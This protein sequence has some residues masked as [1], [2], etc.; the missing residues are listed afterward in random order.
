M[1]VVIPHSPTKELASPPVCRLCS[2]EGSPDLFLFIVQL[3]KTLCVYIF[4]KAAMS[5]PSICMDTTGPK[6]F[7]KPPVNTTKP[8]LCTP[9]ISATAFHEF[10]DF[11]KMDYTQ[12]WGS[13]CWRGRR[14]EKKSE[15]KIGQKR[16]LTF[17]LCSSHFSTQAAGQT[18]LKFF[19]KN[20]QGSYS[21][22]CKLP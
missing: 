11:F 8:F 18:V 6:V 20:W 3:F 12:R 13:R 14:P 2:Q 7:T 10:C 22:P 1:L 21:S 17:S 15:V 5:L 4:L 16:I 19:R 9:C